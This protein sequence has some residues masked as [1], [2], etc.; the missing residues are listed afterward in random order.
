MSSKESAFFSGL[1]GTHEASKRE[2]FENQGFKGWP[3][4]KEQDMENILVYSF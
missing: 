1:S 4:V 2:E 3:I